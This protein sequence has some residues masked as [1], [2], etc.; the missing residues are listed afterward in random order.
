MIK[1]IIQFSGSLEK[2]ILI[3]ILIFLFIIICL[4]TKIA[5]IAQPIYLEIGEEEKQQLCQESN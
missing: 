5:F 3:S 2:W 4:L 1:S